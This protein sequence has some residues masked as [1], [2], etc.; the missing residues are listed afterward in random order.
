MSVAS[1]TPSAMQRANKRVRDFVQAIPKNVVM[2]TY[3]PA[4]PTRSVS[5]FTSVSSS[6][7]VRSSKPKSKTMKDSVVRSSNAFDL[8][9]IISDALNIL[10]S[11][12]QVPIFAVMVV[13]VFAVVLTSGP[14]VSS[15]PIGKLVNDSIAQNGTFGLWVRDNPSKFFG[16]LIFLPSVYTVPSAYSYIAAVVSVLWIYIVPPFTVISYTIQSAFLYIYLKTGRASTRTFLSMLV[17][18]AYYIG[19]LALSPPVVAAS[20]FNSHGRY[21]LDCSTNEFCYDR[22]GNSVVC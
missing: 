10:R 11:V 20:C 2:S 1:K 8:T 13:L 21:Q 16:M 19:Y 14:T 4:R 22:L 17:I 3:T 5:D 15:G 7:N 12:L 6:N 18:L 9:A